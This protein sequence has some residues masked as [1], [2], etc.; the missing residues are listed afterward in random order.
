MVEEGLDPSSLVYQAIM[1]NPTVQLGLNNPRCLLGTALCALCVM[2]VCVCVCVMCVCVYNVCVR[3]CNCVCVM[4]VLICVCLSTKPLWK[5]ALCG[6]VWTTHVAYSILG[7]ALCVCVFV[8]SVFICVHCVFL[9][10]I[11]KQDP[12]T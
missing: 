5:T 10:S 8:M 3:V 11:L 4:F 2:S 1:E 7:T 6:F 12:N 9:S